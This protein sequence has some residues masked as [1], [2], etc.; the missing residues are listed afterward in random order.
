MERFENLETYDGLV[1]SLPP[2]IM[3]AK[4]SWK[5]EIK[6]KLFSYNWCKYL[7]KQVKTGIFR[8]KNAISKIRPRY[9]K[10]IRKQEKYG[11]CV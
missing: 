10:D 3:L 8:G 11:W 5:T 1:P 4:N 6:L 2:K 9:L 7:N